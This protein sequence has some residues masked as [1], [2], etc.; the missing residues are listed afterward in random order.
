[1]EGLDGRRSPRRGEGIF[2]GRGPEIAPRT[3]GRAPL[4]GLRSASWFQ[5][6]AKPAVGPC[7]P[8]RLRSSRRRGALLLR[9]PRVVHLRPADVPDQRGAATGGRARAAG[10][11]T[12]PRPQLAGVEPGRDR[13][14]APGA[15][16]R[17]RCLV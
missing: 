2:D 8:A 4:S 14:A 17:R 15:S 6:D 9:S 5:A 11:S 10:P 12:T 16:G 7:T 13:A 3:C 1:P